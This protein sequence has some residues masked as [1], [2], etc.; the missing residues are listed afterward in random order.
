MVCA[1]PLYIMADTLTLPEPVKFLTSGF[2]ATFPKSCRSGRSFLMSSPRRRFFFLRIGH[3]YSSVWS[4]DSPS[5]AVLP[6]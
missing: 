3:T 6:S 5:W 4:V 1:A 2:C